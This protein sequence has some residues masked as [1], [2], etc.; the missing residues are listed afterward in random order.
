MLNLSREDQIEYN[1]KY[2]WH[3]SLRDDPN[4]PP[5]LK[6]WARQQISML[7]D[8]YAKRQIPTIT[9]VISTCPC[10]NCGY[11]ITLT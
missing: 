8:E 11:E 10:P 1:E 4:S 9:K 3:Q 2:D 5:I 6:K 7:Y